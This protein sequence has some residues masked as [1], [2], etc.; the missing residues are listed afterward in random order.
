MPTGYTA[1]LCDED[2]SF[3][4]FLWTAVR[5]MGAFVHMRDHSSDTKLRF[6]KPGWVQ[7]GS[8]IAVQEREDALRTEEE[9]LELLGT[10]SPAEI[11]HAYDAFKRK[12][13][14]DY[15]ADHA[16]LL[17]V[18]ERLAKMMI[19]VAAWDPPTQD[20]VGFK[21]F[22]AQQLEE[23]IKWDGS[24]PDRPV[25]E[26]S[27]AEWHEE[28]TRYQIRRIERCRELLQQETDKPDVQQ[29]RVDWIKALMKSVPP[30]PC[31]FVE[32]PLESLGRCID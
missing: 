15:E 5:A 17:P 26:D 24:L 14:A 16:R 13:L 22:M 23:T 1:K 3:E 4:E 27:A 12:S 11:E 9:E 10:K 8:A 21:E 28:C 29:A 31:R 20:H 25:F 32:S 19:D 30:P 18:H 7:V 6:P 2:Q